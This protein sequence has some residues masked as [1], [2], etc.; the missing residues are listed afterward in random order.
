MILDEYSHNVHLFVDISIS[1]ATGLFSI[2]TH[3]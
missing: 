3:I 1:F 2:T